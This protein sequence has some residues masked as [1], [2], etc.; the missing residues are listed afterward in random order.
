MFNRLWAPLLVLMGLGFLALR[1]RLSDRRLIRISLL[2]TLV[3]LTLMIA[4]NMSEY[5]VFHNLAHGSAARDLSWMTVLLGWLVVLISGTVAGI[6]ALAGRLTPAWVG[7][8]LIAL[9]PATIVFAALAIWLLG[10]PLGVASAV[11]GIWLV[12]GRSPTIAANH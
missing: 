10:V 9:L 4:G 8:S 2:I 5:W 12:A 3:G 1:R 6:G 7:W 11:S